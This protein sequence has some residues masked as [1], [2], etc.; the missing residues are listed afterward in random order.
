MHT[1]LSRDLS[2]TWTGTCSQQRASGQGTATWRNPAGSITTVITGTQINGVFVGKEVYD[3]YSADG[4]RVHWEGSVEHGK[5]QGHVLFESYK[6]GQLA[7]RYVGDVVDGIQNGQGHDA[8]YLA[9]GS[10][11]GEFNGIWRN[12]QGVSANDVAG[13][14][15]SGSASSQPYREGTDT[16]S[17]SAA[18]KV[19]PAVAGTVKL[20]AP[21]A[22]TDSALQADIA[23]ANDFWSHAPINPMGAATNPLKD[24]PSARDV[25]T[26]WDIANFYFERYRDGLETKPAEEWQW[27]SKKSTDDFRKARRWY[28]MILDQEHTELLNPRCKSG[29]CTA[30][31]L[32]AWQGSVQEESVTLKRFIKICEDQLPEVRQKR[33]AQEAARQEREDV[34]RAKEMAPELAERKHVG[35]TVC[36]TSLVILGE[37]DR[38]EK[39]KILIRRQL[40]ENGY[41]NTFAGIYKPARDWEES[42]WVD[43]DAVV[44]CH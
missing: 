17:A 37:V 27:S 16:A 15:L 31:Q 8:T 12:G 6:Y 20:A 18:T 4:E 26:K 14:D 36:N 42:H 22:V 5:M 11:T 9:D 35:D 44:A 33:I 3:A 32:R 25:G 2:V 40:H 38:V 19:A 30:D 34:K 24:D 41:I 7:H 39:G 29:P 10:L 13:N 43:Y 1:L 21:N 23:E 28:Q